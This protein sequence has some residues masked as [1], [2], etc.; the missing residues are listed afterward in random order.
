MRHKPD[1]FEDEGDERPLYVPLNHNLKKP[2]ANCPFRKKG[3][4]E[5]RPGRVKG[6]IKTLQH[7]LNYFQCHKTTHGAA[8]E[9][10]MCMGSIA[11][12]FKHTGRLSVLT[13]LALMRK[14]LTIK[15]IT[16]C[17]PL[18]LDPKDVK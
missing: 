11:Y 9:E 4:I 5:L 10:S 3:A 13:R 12:M 18:L 8:R 17:Y 6:I 15:D 16:D 1:P 14:E 7:D 2:C